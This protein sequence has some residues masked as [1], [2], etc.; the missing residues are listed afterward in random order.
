[1]IPGVTVVI[2]LWAILSIGLI[3]ILAG[4]AAISW[5]FRKKKVDAVGYCTC[6]CPDCVAL[7]DIGYH[8]CE[9]S[10]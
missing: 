6:R 5:I 8:R 4:G 10:A 9:H 1:M 7:D 2:L 3:A